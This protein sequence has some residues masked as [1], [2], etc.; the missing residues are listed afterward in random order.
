[1]AR[2]GRDPDHIR[3]L[4][5]LFVVVGDTLAEAQAKHALLDSMVHYDSGIR[6]LNI[7][8]GHDVSGFDP[9]GPLPPIAETGASRS[10]QQQMLEYVR[11]RPDIT[12]RELAQ[13]AGSYSGLAFVGTPGM[14]AD[15]MEEWLAQRACDGFN[16]MFPYLP[17]GLE[18]FCD[19]VVP[20]LQRRGIYRKE[21]AGTTLRDHL[22]LPR[23]QNRFF[24]G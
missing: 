5:G 15:A 3:I 7:M 6:S 4:P 19:K 11:A 14:I 8:L 22:G 24:P 17:G 21:Y 23:P 12:I 13:K 16:I 2:F 1:M 9:D 18:D 10:G 20:E